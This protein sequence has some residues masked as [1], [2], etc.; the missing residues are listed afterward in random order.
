[1]DRRR[2]STWP[3]TFR[4]CPEDISNYDS[5]RVRQPCRPINFMRLNLSLTRAP[6]SGLELSIVTVIY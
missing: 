4:D 2:A 3:P 5:T 6:R 1:M